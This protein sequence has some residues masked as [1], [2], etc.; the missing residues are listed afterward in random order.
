MNII[1]AILT[2]FF[3]AQPL[4]RATPESQGVP[5]EAVSALIDRLEEQNGMVHSY[6][7]IR[8][9]KVIAEGHWEPFNASTPHALYSVSKSFVSMAIGFAVND[10]L[11]SLDDRVV[12]F[13]P[14][15]AEINSDEWLKDM[16]VRDL[17]A[18]A[19]G[20]KSDTFRAIRSAAP[21]EAAKAFYQMPMKDEPGKLFRYMSGNTAM[22]ALIHAKVTGEKDL[23]AYLKPRVFDKLGITSSYW[24]RLKDGTTVIGGSGYELKSEELAKICLL[25]LNN[26]VWQGERILPLWWVREAT[27]LQTPYGNVTDS[28]LA[29]HGAK[30]G[31]AAKPDDWQLGYGWQL[32]MGHHESFRLCGAFGQIGSVVPDKDIIFVSNAGGRSSN[33]PSLN[34]F[35]D[36]ILPT[37]SEKPLPENPAALRKLRDRSSKLLI[38]PPQNTAEPSAAALNAFK[39]TKIDSAN[40]LAIS[41]IGYD[42]KTKTLTVENRFGKQSI[43]VGNGKWETGR[44]TAEEENSDTLGRISGGEQPVAAA[45]AWTGPDRF[46]VRIKFI[47]SPANLDID[48]EMRDGRAHV[49]TR[50]NMS[51]IY[52]IELK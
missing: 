28:V 32:W 30:S 6:M 40:A 44:F 26:G 15:D 51:K 39:N 43:R 50:S 22:L 1:A 42:D 47:R 23:L 46:T 17:M 27:S 29:L 41:G 48:F 11:M 16:R 13:F 10:R 34:A 45:G 19:S 5:S 38:A 20:Q 12:K 31:G 2:P 21:G 8:H 18:M 14:E 35:Y 25:L 52:T 33:K 24:P 4:P 36:T 3:C 9:G 7:L 37:L 49:S